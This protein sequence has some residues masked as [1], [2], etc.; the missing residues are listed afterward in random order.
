MNTQPGRSSAAPILYITVAARLLWGMAVDCPSVHNAAWI[1]PLIGLLITLPF[2]LACTSAAGLGNDSPVNNLAARCPAPIFSLSLA[3]FAILLLLD[4]AVNMRMLA[5]TANVLALG[6]L[7]IGVLLIP[8]AA[9]AAVSVLLG[10]DAAGNSARIWLHLLPLPLLVLLIA[11][12]GS[13]EPGWLTPVLGD[14]LRRILSGGVYCGGGIALLC[15]PFLVS[16]PDRNRRSPILYLAL[17]VLTSSL[18]LAVL[19]MLCPPLTTI[20]LSRSSRTEL[21]LNNGRVR[22]SMQLLLIILWYGALT[23]LVS[24]EASAAACAI[25]RLLP[26]AP[27]WSLAAC[28]GLLCF[29]LACLPISTPDQCVHIFNWYYPLAGIALILPLSFAFRK[30]RK[31]PCA[32]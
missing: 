28:V 4:C 3:I 17:A 1:C 18:L 10:M 2:I 7:P 12:A 24:A 16:V 30:W 11:Q 26:K 14:G 20:L 13:C 31:D 25:S 32:D 19:Q 8:L 6:N 27:R 29:I 15:F 5:G 23:H 21:I 22:L 9:I